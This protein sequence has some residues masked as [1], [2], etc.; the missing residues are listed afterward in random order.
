MNDISQVQLDVFLLNVVGLFNDTLREILAA[1][2][3]RLFAAVLALLLAVSLL[4]LLVRQGRR[5]R[6]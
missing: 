2:I 4:G 3:L 5:G 6:L 1:P